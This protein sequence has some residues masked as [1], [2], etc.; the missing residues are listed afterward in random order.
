M[1]KNTTPL[2][3]VEHKRVVQFL[4]RKGLPHF[5][6]NN[7]MWT[8]SI[9]QKLRA[10]EMGV[11]SGVPDLFVV[12]PSSGG[13]YSVNDYVD[14]DEQVIFNHRLVVIEMKRRKGGV[15]SENQK[16]WLEIL[17]AAGVEAVVCNGADEAIKW[18]TNRLSEGL[19]DEN[20]EVF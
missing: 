5:H 19:E 9:K 15:T 4:V 3:D 13:K 6:V 1:P 12:I 16:R 14:I 11:S 10:K 20:E 8:K 7:E 18:L 2:E 17:N